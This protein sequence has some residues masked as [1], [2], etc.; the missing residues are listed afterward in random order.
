MNTIDRLKELE[1]AATSVQWKWY[2]PNDDGEI[3]IE[4]SGASG[5]QDWGGLR[6]CPNG[7]SKRQYEADTEL[8][9]AARNALPALLK[10]AEAAKAYLH[11]GSAAT[12]V[13]ARSKLDAA[14]A[15]LEAQ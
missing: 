3:I 5:T 8:V 9:A 14:L 2:P 13:D 4:F 15:E 10:V 1:K 12:C 6:V 7:G 11:A